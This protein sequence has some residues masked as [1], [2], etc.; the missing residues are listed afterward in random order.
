MKVT[1][2]KVSQEIRLTTQLKTHRPLYYRTLRFKG[3]LRAF[4]IWTVVKHRAVSC[5]ASELPLLL[6]PS[7]QRKRGRDG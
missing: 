4:G 3:E 6:K 7:V 1:I 5:F 2:G